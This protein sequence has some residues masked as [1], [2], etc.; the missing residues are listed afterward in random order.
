MAISEKPHHKCLTTAVS[1]PNKHE[2]RGADIKM[3]VCSTPGRSLLQ[4]LCKLR[5]IST[6][7]TS[8]LLSSSLLTLSIC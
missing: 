5:Y 6:L 3:A 8:S 2:A 1:A 7:D 4:L